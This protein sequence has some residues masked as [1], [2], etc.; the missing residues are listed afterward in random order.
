MMIKRLTALLLALIIVIACMTSCKTDRSNGG[1]NTESDTSSTSEGT[2]SES[3]PPQVKVVLELIKDGKSDFKIIY[4]G[5]SSDNG[6]SLAYK[7]KEEIKN[8]YGVELTVD[9]DYLAS[10]EEADSSAFEILIG[11]TNRPESAQVLEKVSGNSDYAI[12]AVG[13]KLVFAASSSYALSNSISYFIDTIMAKSEGNGMKDLTFSSDQNYLYTHNYPMGNMTLL[14]AP[15]GDYRIVVGNDAELNETR[16]ALKLSSFIKNL[17]GVNLDIVRDDTESTD[18]E[19]LVGKTSRTTAEVTNRYEYVVSVTDKKLEL[20][21]DSVYGYECLLYHAE[22]VLT[23]GTVKSEDKINSG[24]VS[25]NNIASELKNGTENILGRNGEIRIMFH[26]IWGWNESATNPTEQRNLML[27]LTY[28]EYM[29]DILCLQ[30]CTAMMRNPEKNPIM[31]TLAENGYA[32]VDVGKVDG[33]ETATPIFYRTS[34][35]KV[36]EK[37]VLKF[38]KNMGGGE[39]KFVTWA[40]FETIDG[41][42]KFGVLSVHLA[43]QRTEQGNQYRL[44]QVP[45]VVEIAEQIEAK[46]SCAVLIGGDMN[47]YVNEDPYNL[48]LNKGLTDVWNSVSASGQR[49]DG[50][51]NY[52][53]PT[54][55]SE[56]GIFE[57]AEITSYGKYSTGSVDHVF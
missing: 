22:S 23:S 34:V 37:G 56:L 57:R 7:L 12:E 9:D 42:K 13:N 32:E 21:A 52:G 43:Y 48:Y 28:L 33:Y 26:N 50:K 11:K 39:D 18:R 1:V 5:D 19:I 3:E 17:V 55:N 46:Y 14:G 38:D 20:L 53:Y 36:L 41:G 47:C 4:S 15:V 30:E 49:D 24:V 6:I 40:V 35:L 2:E 25:R 27:G 54:F 51:S 45:Q 16:L 44:A 31:A 29:P 8:K 10:G